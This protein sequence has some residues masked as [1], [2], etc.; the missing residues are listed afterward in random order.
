MRRSELIHIISESIKRQLLNEISIRD[1]YQKEQGR[2]KWSADEFQLICQSDPTYNR[3]KDIVGKYT[4]WLLNKLN[5]IEQLQQVRIP[6]E[7]YADG[8]KRGI[9]QRNGV[10]TDI[11]KFKTINK[12]SK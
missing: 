10:P 11:N 3:D 7:W 8:M 9:L 6:L 4:N 2:T 5:S 1:K 12:I